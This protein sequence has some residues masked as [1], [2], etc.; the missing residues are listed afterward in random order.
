MTGGWA[1]PMG[2]IK[3]TIQSVDQ[4]IDFDDPLWAQMKPLADKLLY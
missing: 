3:G 2:A 4:W 1:F